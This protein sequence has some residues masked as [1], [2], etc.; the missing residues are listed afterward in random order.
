MHDPP[1]TLRFRSPAARRIRR[2]ESALVAQ[3]VH[4]LSERRAGTRRAPV[5][6]VPR[7]SG[8]APSLF[9]AEGGG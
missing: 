2:R 4:Q 5:A 3:Y 8:A 1:S 7:R 9:S 6:A